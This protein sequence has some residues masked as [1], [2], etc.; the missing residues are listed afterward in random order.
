MGGKNEILLTESYII[1]IRVDTCC[2]IYVNQVGSE[3]KSQQRESE[4]R[5]SLMVQRP[6]EL[7]SN[8][9]TIWAA[10]V[11]GPL[12]GQCNYRA[13]KKG[14]TAGN[15]TQA[16]GLC[17]VM[18]LPSQRSTNNGGPDCVLIRHHRH[19][20]LDHTGVPA[21]GL[22]LLDLTSDPI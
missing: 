1:L 12:R 8:K 22:P 21:I 6:V 19:L 4:G 16:L 3:V 11:C 10:T 2:I 7:V 5:G 14:G 9:D 13:Q 15:R 17:P 20:S 18:A